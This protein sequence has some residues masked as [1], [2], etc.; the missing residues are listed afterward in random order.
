MTPGSGRFLRDNA[1]LVAAAALPLIVVA[2]FLLS[3]AI[4]RWTVPPP[5]YDF[6]LRADGG[7]DGPYTSVAVDFTVREGTV[8]ATVRSTPAENYRLAARLFLFHHETMAVTEI[9]VAL[10][11]T[12]AEGDSPLTIAV[13]ALAGRRVV[14]EATAPDGY[15]LEN[16]SQGGSGLVGELFGMRRYGSR[17][18]LVNRGRVVPIDLPTNR[19]VY[20]STVRAIGWLQDG[21]GTGAK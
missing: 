14:A 7:Y 17:A 19:Y 10:P 3:T 15:R 2:F 8:E 4:P 6:L 9:P 18:A 21:D 20:T 16:R 1:F 13:D 5:A 12:L 11:N